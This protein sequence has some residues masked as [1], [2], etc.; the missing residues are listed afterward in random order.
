M[1]TGFRFCPSRRRPSP[2]DWTRCTFFLLA[3][4]AFFT[5]LIF[6]LVVYFALKYRRRTP[7]ERP[8]RRP[9]RHW[10]SRSL[11]R[12]PV[13]RVDGDV[14]LGRPGLLQRLH[15]GPPTRWTSTSSASSG[16][17]RSSTPTARREINELHVPDRPRGAA[18]D[19]VAGR[20]PQL[21]HPGLPREAGRGARPLHDDVR[22]RRPRSASTT[23]SAPSTAARSTRG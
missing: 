10:R 2:R 22:S 16:C 8:A 9:S 23:C 12:C 5:L 17:G 13:P 18:D 21:L 15:G 6:V 20:D 14:L 19:G 7:D 1:N 4:S 11:R 3:V